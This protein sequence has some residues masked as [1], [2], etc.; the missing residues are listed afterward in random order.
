[1]RKAIQSNSKSV[2]FS[3]VEVV[4]ATGIVGSILVAIATALAYTMKLDIQSQYRS[5]ATAKAQEAG[6]FFRRERTVLGWDD[7]T[8]ILTDD[9]IYCIDFIPEEPSTSVED[10]LFDFSGQGQEEE[11]EGEEGEFDSDGVYPAP[12]EGCGYRLS[13]TNPTINY[14]R[15]ALVEKLSDSVIELTVAVYWDNEKSEDDFSV[16]LKQRLS[17]W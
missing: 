10:H 4:V 1:M 15:Q 12:V 17:R 13:V 14:K 5:L 9:E 3:L 16:Q 8:A 6:D 11:G 2:G 7:F